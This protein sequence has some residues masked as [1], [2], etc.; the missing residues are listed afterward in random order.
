MAIQFAEPSFRIHNILRY[1]QLNSY[2]TYN[3]NHF[4][5]N[6]NSNFSNR[7]TATTLNGSRCLRH[8]PHVIKY[9]GFCWQ[10]TPIRYINDNNRCSKIIQYRIRCKRRGPDVVSHD[11]YCYQHR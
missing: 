6:L 8:G 3:N 7:C 2:W 1:N 5:N 4:I 11:G 9:N 10:H